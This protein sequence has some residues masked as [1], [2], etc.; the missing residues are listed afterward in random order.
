MKAENILFC[1]LWVGPGKPQMPRL[2]APIMKTI[3]FLTTLGIQVTTLGIQVSTP[4]G[5]S[6]IRAKLAI[7]IFDL[8]AKASALCIKQYNGKYGCTVCEHPGKRLSNRANVY[9]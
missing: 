3:R 1:G 9:L 8:P 2:L 5:L 6:T 4:C 7:G